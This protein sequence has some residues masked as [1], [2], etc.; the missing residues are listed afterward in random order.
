MRF[1]HGELD[2]V[3]VPMMG[4]CFAVVG[5]EL[6]FKV[7]PAGD[8]IRDGAQRAVL[9]RL[10]S[11]IH[12]ILGWSEEV[13]LAIPGDLRAWDC[14]ISGRVPRPWRARV[15]AETNVADTQA[16]ERRFRLKARDD[17]NGL[18]I[19]LLSD[20]L[21]NRAALPALR[22]GLRDLLP[23][24]AREILAALKEGREPPGSGIVIL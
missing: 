15:E 13:P 19:L 20:T 24:G 17:P 21:A 18:L 23:C 6:S 1:E 7:Y 3:S 11:R 8:P 12:P 22:D 9:Q 2:E 14:V 5:L 10:R 16:L 4:G